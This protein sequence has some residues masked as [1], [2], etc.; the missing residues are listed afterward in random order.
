VPFA[1]R[2]VLELGMQGSHIN[3]KERGMLGQLVGIGRRAPL[4]PEA[5]AEVLGRCTFTNGADSAV[6]LELYRK[7]AT[8]LLGSAKALRFERLVWAAED[9]ID[10]GQSLRYCSAL[11]KLALERMEFDEA[12]SAAVKAWALPTSLRQLD[13]Y[14]CSSLRALPELSVCPS[15]KA[16]GL[17]DCLSLID[18]PDV[19][20]LPALEVS[21]LPIHLA[22]WQRG[23]YKAWIC[24]E[25]PAEVRRRTFA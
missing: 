3:C 17:F 10:L 8:A 7:T 12:G 5:F 23:G 19:S 4:A 20:S 16:I 2:T 6:V 15:L 25:D 9:Y 18:V 14:E 11:E 24:K 1:Q 13:L 22:P 21:D